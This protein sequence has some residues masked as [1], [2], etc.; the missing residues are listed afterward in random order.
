MS[1]L[2]GIVHSHGAAGVAEEAEDFLAGLVH[3]NGPEATASTAPLPA[4]CVFFVH[5]CFHKTYLWILPIQFVDFSSFLDFLGRGGK[6]GIS[7]H[8]HH[9]AIS[10]YQAD[11]CIYVFSQIVFV[12]FL[13]RCSKTV[14]LIYDTWANLFS[15]MCICGFLCVFGCICGFF[16]YDLWIGSDL[17]HM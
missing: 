12:D 13:G 4:V 15:I 2:E 1:L 14:N 10:S 8:S 17:P 3:G 11:L 5:L 6:T 9:R 16:K 7:S